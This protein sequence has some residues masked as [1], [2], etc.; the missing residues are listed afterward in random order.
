MKMQATRILLSL[1]PALL[2]LSA[3]FPVHAQEVMHGRVSSSDSSGLVKGTGD[4]DWSF[5]TVNSLILPG[6]SIWADEEG[7]LELEFSSGTFVRLADGS[8]LDIV[9][10]PPSAI[11]RGVSGSFYVHRIRRGKGDV[12]FETPV[13]TLRVAPNTQVRIDILLEG[14]TTVSVRWGRVTVTTAGN[15]SVEV[16]QGNRIYIDPGYLP[17]TPLPFDVGQEDAF[18]TWNRER[19]RLLA[20]GYEEVPVLDTGYED[21]PIGVSDLTSYGEWIYVDDD[22]YWRPTVIH[23]YVPYRH[24]YWS[25]AYDGYVWVGHHPFS[26]VTSHY[27]YWDY[28]SHY[29]WIWGYNPYYSNAYAATLHYG[30]YFV[31]SPLNRHGYPV[32]YGNEHFTVGGSHFSI[33]GSSYSLAADLLHGAALVHGLTHDIVNRHHGDRNYVWNIYGSGSRYADRHYRG[34]TLRVRDYSPQRVMRGPSVGGVNGATARSRV[35]ALD[36]RAASRVQTA[37]AANRTT[38]S[39]QRERTA[40]AS[41]NRRA[42]TR[43]ARVNQNTVTTTIANVRRAERHANA[44]RTLVNRRAGAGSTETLTNA[45]ATGSRPTV[46]R[47]A[48]GTR[49]TRIATIPPGIHRSS[50]ASRSTAR[51]DRRTPDTNTTVASRRPERG[52]SQSRVTSTS[53]RSSRTV[54]PQSSA[55]PEAA[56]SRYPEVRPTPSRTREAAPSQ[57]LSRSTRV[58][59]PSRNA[60]T[61]RNTSRVSSPSQRTRSV[62][63]APAAPRSSTRVSSPPSRS[64]S[65]RSVSRAPS[66]NRPSSRVSSA[67]RSRPSSSISRSSRSS[68]PS[69]ISAPSR[70][71]SRSA[72][73]SR[74]STPSRTSSLSG[75]SRSTSRGSASS[76]MSAP[77]RSSSPSISSRGSSRSSSF[78]SGRSSSRGASRGAVGR[79][80]GRSGR[81]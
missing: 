33:Y 66:T 60:T 61:S 6:D 47:T 36:S 9:S 21:A 44:T 69:R 34:T 4:A 43:V 45:S 62:N 41:Q 46:S 18:D 70:S 64:S 63:S 26:Y 13:G 55:R 30:D 1:A 56:P 19:A 32:H 59:S 40:L 48:R 23:D 58:S 12:T 49:S 57:N 81:R 35:A 17:S 31:W 25:Y 8:K 73:S 16:T 3:T 14:P 5:A 27:G 24:G 72:A 39:G 37:S 29:G 79:S 11:F 51:D 20:V 76:R 7:A 71:S 77:S 15:D 52:S 65:N 54:A 10:V 42:A 38:R 50:G 22:Y 78:S 80:A 74:M 75:A 53:Q 28:N 67:P 2:V 68:A